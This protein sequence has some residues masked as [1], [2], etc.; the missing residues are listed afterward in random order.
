ML[1]VFTR[2]FA[3]SALLGLFMSPGLVAQQHTNTASSPSSQAKTSDASAPGLTPV[4]DPATAAQIRELLQ[5]TGA[6]RNATLMVGRM[7]D[8]M[9]QQAP[10]F[11]P[12]DFWTDMNQSFQHLDAESLMVPYFQ[13]YYSKPDVEKAIA[14]YKTPAG[15]HL[16]AVQPVIMQ[17]TQGIVLARAQEVGHQVLMR[18]KAEL[19]ALAKQ[20]QQQH[21]AGGP[22]PQNAAP[23][24]Q[25]QPKR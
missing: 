17:K 24:S 5:V 18:H 6:T 23:G 2:S 15:K 20:Y 19:E 25:G 16:V 4:S 8:Q 10:S 9:K 21:G 3:T 7:I 14:F 22:A 11:F 12:Q 13:K 1:R